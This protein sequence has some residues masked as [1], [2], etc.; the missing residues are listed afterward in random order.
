MK[1]A[2]KQVES[3]IAAPDASHQACLLYGPDSGLSRERVGKI[4]TAIL[5][6]NDDPFAFVEFEASQ[7]LE[8][9]ARLSDELGAISLMGGKRLI[10]IRDATDKCTKVVEEAASA[11]HADAF[12]LVAAG[13]LTTRSSLRSWFEKQKNCAALAAYKDEI[14]DVAGIIRQR[15]SEVGINADRDC[16]EYLSQQL[17]NDRYVTRQEL[18]KIITYAGDEK[19][20]SLD[21]VRLLVDYNRDTAFDDIVNAVASKNLRDMEKT[22]TNALREGMVPVAY[23][24][25]LQRYFN[26]LYAMRA[27]MD[28]GQSAEMVIK[29][30]RPPVFFRQVPLM[31]RHLQQWSLPALAKALKL[32]VEAELVCKSS[33]VPPAPA[34]TR[35]LMQLTQL[36]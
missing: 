12:L 18:E 19:T 6:G 31:T 35:K 13:E 3:F 16:V 2:P 29:S 17:G 15:F 32:L 34:S 33:D 7:L 30:S 24:R 28:E 23:L 1:I 21:E 10:V 25:A 36:R 14:R 22:L 8:D 5:A 11:F 20:I 27:Q 9:T 4:K 26:R